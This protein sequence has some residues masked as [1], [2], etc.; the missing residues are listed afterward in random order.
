MSKKSPE[1]RIT[2]TWWPQR[3]RSR[4]VASPFV[5]W[6]CSTKL[7]DLRPT[8]DTISYLFIKDNPPAK[9]PSRP[10]DSSRRVRFDLRTW[11]KVGVL[12]ACLA[13]RSRSTPGNF[14]APFQNNSLKHERLLVGFNQTAYGTNKVSTP[15]LIL[16]SPG[17]TVL[18]GSGDVRAQING[19]TERKSDGFPLPEISEVG[20]G[21]PL[22]PRLGKSE[23]EAIFLF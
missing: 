4:A 3:G 16:F 6:I 8:P 2:L 20:R 9:H 17:H 5:R 14:F 10:H 19:P 7:S 21:G 23:P 1:S 13:Q 12:N 15:R 18:G 22:S 11:D